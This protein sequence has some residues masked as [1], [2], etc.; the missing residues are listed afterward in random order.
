MARHTAVCEKHP[1]RLLEREIVQLKMSLEGRDKAIALLNKG[2]ES[3]CE[4][5]DRLKQENRALRTELNAWR[6]Q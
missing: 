4:E 3:Q 1:S 6:S 5:M 2:M